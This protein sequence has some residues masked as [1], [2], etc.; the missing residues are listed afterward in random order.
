MSKKLLNRAY[1]YPA[2]ACALIIIG[3]TYAFLFSAISS[4][5]TTSYL[6]I[7]DDDDI[8]SVTT[9]LDGITAGFGASAV[10]VLARH[11]GYAGHIRTGRYALEPDMGALVFFRHLRNGQ[12]EPVRLVIPSVRTKQRFAEEVCSELMLDTDSLLLA[13]DDSATCAEYGLDTC[14]IMSM[15]IPN[16]YE[17]YW[18]IPLSKF[19]KKMKTENDRFWA[20]ERQQ[21][22]DALQLS[23]VEVITLASIIDEETANNGEKPMI[24][25]MYYNRL[26]QGMPL[27]ADPTIKYALQQF[28]L[29]RIYT[30]LLNV[31][32]PYNTYRNTGLPPGPI[33]IPSVAGIDAVLNLVHHD[34]LYMCAKEDFSG[35]HNF[36]R[37][38]A[39]HLANAAKYS[40]ALNARSIK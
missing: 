39:E 13:L 28:E 23:P 32:S 26:K 17:L 35:T 3:I 16:T 18:N 37:T 9:K 15:F 31:E 8:D 34:Y 25:G 30:K 11:T 2:L 6:Y 19:L 20:G 4:R 38:Y 33:R 27:Q 7:D 5:D 22:A 10:S 29:R 12:Q 24:A 14:T 21:K 40:A 1:L 36:A